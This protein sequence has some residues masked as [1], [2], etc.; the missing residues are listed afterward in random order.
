MQRT[1]HAPL[2]VRCV[3]SERPSLLFLLLFFMQQLVLLFAS[4][5]P[6]PDEL[7]FFS[8]L[9]LLL[10]IFSTHLTRATWRSNGSC[11]CCWSGRIVISLR[12]LCVDLLEVERGVK[13]CCCC[14]CSVCLSVCQVA[15]EAS[16]QEFISHPTKNY[17]KAHCKGGF[18]FFFFFF[19]IIII[20]INL[21]RRPVFQSVLPTSPLGSPASLSCLSHLGIRRAGGRPGLSAARCGSPAT[22]WKTIARWFLA[23]MPVK[24]RKRKKRGKRKRE[25]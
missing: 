2:Q 13:C 17:T 21:A 8:V 5:G 6:A 22:V 4:A 10:L 9:L 1:V 12:C 25:E 16:L 7:G 11:W 14:C 24:V 18:F 23:V 3:C 20:I 19:N 15:A